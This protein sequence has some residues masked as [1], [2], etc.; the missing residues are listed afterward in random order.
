MSGSSEVKNAKKC[1]L[2][3]LSH[4][5]FPAILLSSEVLF[6]VPINHPYKVR[7]NHPP[8]DR[9]RG[10]GEPA[11]A[12]Q[13]SVQSRTAKP[14]NTTP[15]WWQ[16]L[17][18]IYKNRGEYHTNQDRCKHHTHTYKGATGLYKGGARWLQDIVTLFHRP[19]H[20]LGQIFCPPGTKAE[21]QGSNINYTER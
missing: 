9:T 6:Q 5:Q 13:H 14:E 8:R 2:G 3:Q 11:H 18:P 7:L 4:E 17:E 10:G 19:L 1:E 12:L 15:T 21:E 16:T 20:P